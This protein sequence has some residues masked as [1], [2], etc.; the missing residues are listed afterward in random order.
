MSPSGDRP[1]KTA[2]LLRWR[3]RAALRRTF[4]YASHLASLAALHLDRFERPGRE[5]AFR[6]QLSAPSSNV[7]CSTRHTFWTSDF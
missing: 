6:S 5:E 4:Q 3:A 7:P 1:L 2:H